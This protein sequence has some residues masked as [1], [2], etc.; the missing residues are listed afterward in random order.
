MLCLFDAIE[1]F[2][3]VF[4]KWRHFGD[5]YWGEYMRATNLKRS[6]LTLAS[7]AA[8]V[9]AIGVVPAS[10]APGTITQTDHQSTLTGANFPLGATTNNGCP[11]WLNHDFVDFN[12][13]GHGVTHATQNGAGDFWFTSTFEGT[14]TVAFYAGAVVNNDDPNNPYI[15]SLIGTP[16]HTATGHFTQW[17]G[18]EGNHSNVVIHGTGTFVGTFDGSSPITLH[19]HQQVAFNALGQPVVNMNVASCS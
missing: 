3:L 11:D 9:V 19:F 7:A 8:M 17:F 16:D 1:H 15:V 4:A 18:F 5:C 14:G 12:L 2:S 10:A 13:T 6:L